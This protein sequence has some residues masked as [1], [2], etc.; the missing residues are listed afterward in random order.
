MGKGIHENVVIILCKT[1]NKEKL[2]VSDIDVRIVAEAANMMVILLCD[3][4]TTT[5]NN[6]IICARR[7]RIPIK[8]IG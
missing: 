7:P 6:I 4:K 8:Y 3:P 5:Y 1:L 2:E